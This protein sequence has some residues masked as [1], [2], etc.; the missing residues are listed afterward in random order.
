VGD[1]YL[2]AQHYY[3]P[4]ALTPSELR[5]NA[6]NTEPCIT[7]DNKQITVTQAA[8]L[9]AYYSAEGD[10]VKAVQLQSLISTA[11]AQIRTQYPD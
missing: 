1:K 5:E 11:K 9:W 4:A 2:H 8:M 6:Y 10:S 3:A 7:W